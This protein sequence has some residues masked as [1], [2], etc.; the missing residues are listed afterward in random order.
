M[1]FL[2]VRLLDAVGD[3][4]PLCIAPGDF[5]QLLYGPPDRAE[6]LCALAQFG[7][8]EG[9]A[10]GDDLVVGAA[11]VQ[12]AAATARRRRSALDELLGAALAGTQ[13]E[14]SLHGSQT[15]R[16]AARLTTGKIGPLSSR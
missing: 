15:G 13:G 3:A 2:R 6:A 8:A 7:F 1:V 11:R 10:N 16:E 12:V 9:D 5:P 4:E 14:A